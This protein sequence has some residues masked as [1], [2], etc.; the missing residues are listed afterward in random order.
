MDNSINAVPDFP[1]RSEQDGEKPNR[2]PKH[3]FALLLWS[4]AHDMCH[5]FLQW[6]FADETYDGGPCW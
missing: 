4:L 5:E 6:Y 3:M 2:K 1:D